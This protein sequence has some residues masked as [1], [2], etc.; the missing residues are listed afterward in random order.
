MRMNPNGHWGGN[1]AGGGDETDAA[2]GGTEPSGQDS[3]G[4]NMPHVHMHP[5]NDGSGKVTVHVMHH[6]GKHTKHVHE[7][8]DTEGMAAHIH[9]HFG[10]GEPMMAQDSESDS[11]Y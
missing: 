8:G 5:H 11:G 2:T 3:G 4:S 1:E 7:S 9:E 6:G 10:G